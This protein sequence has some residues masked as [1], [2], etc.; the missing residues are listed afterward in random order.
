M[1]KKSKATKQEQSSQQPRKRV[2]LAD[3]R[4]IQQLTLMDNEFMNVCLDGNIPAAQE[5]LRVILKRED[6]VVKSVE[7]QQH[8]QGV[9]RSIYVDIFAV[10]GEGRPINI[11]VQNAAKGA[12]PRRARFHGAM[13]DTH[14]L[15]MGQDF[16][17]LPDHYII[18][19]TGEDI[20]GYSSA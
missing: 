8:F 14:S 4:R 17:E 20:L 7:T 2:P 5:M 9:K 6:L 13:I 12:S 18:F 16:D 11:E 1:A 15:E 10:D 3:R 19:I